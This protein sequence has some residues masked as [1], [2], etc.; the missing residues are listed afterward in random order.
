[1]NKKIKW[2]VSI[3]CI[4]LAIFSFS[5]VYRFRNIDP[6]TLPISRIAVK[7]AVDPDDPRSVIGD[8]D[9]AFIG[10]IKDTQDVLHPKSLFND[11]PKSITQNKTPY[12]E[13]SVEVVS[14]IKG[15]LKEGETIKMYKMGGIT[16]NGKA[17]SLFEND[18]LPENDKYYIFIAYGQDDGALVTSG[19]FS[20]IELEKDFS[21]EKIDESELVSKY[22]D[23]YENEIDNRK[24][25]RYLC[26]Y[27]INYKE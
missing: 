3:V 20:S 22:K 10:L 19:G 15:V 25:T 2:L 6:N 5:L 21:P 12:T 27:D 14:N 1:M 23:A 18:S 11:F 8:A 4:F 24:D 9:Y 16:P 7:L 13:V 17:L 26:K